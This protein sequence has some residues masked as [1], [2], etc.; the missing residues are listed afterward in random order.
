[1]Q[2]MHMHMPM[3]KVEV[4]MGHVAWPRK[5]DALLRA[6]IALRATRDSRNGEYGKALEALHAAAVEYA[7]AR[8]KALL[9]TSAL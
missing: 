7:E 2:N 1:M 5:R 6:A 3:G 8:E 9:D 4:Q